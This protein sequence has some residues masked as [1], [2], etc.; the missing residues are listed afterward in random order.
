MTST[1]S[2]H[3]RAW[4]ETFDPLLHEH[5]PE[6]PPFDADER[7]LLDEAA[8]RLADFASTR[9]TVTGRGGSD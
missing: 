1:A 4:K 5:A 6:Q 2:L 9:V 3:A 8:G 7:R